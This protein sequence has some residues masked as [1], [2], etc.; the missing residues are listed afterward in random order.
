MASKNG[1]KDESLLE[2]K[3]N[4]EGLEIWGSFAVNICSALLFHVECACHKVKKHVMG[5]AELTVRDT[6]WAW[7][8]NT[9]LQSV[10]R[11]TDEGKCVSHLILSRH[12]VSSLEAF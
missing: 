8:R 10:S 11:A 3:D 12:Q 5:L 6:L 4:V 2:I 9:H 1:L 7:G